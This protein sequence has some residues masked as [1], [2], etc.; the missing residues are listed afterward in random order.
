VLRK[1]QQA[2][3]LT[4]AELET[5]KAK[6]RYFDGNHLFY[7]GRQAFFRGEYRVATRTTPGR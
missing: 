1:M 6:I 4:G 5:V 2:V 3:S 7:E